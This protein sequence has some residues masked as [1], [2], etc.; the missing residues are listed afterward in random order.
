MLMTVIKLV[1][2]NSFDSLQAT[3]LYS[4]TAPELPQERL[5]QMQWVDRHAREKEAKEKPWDFSSGNVQVAHRSIL[6]KRSS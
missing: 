4:C 5:Q 1:Y 6:R 2:L 3:K